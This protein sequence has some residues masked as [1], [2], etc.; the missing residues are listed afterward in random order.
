MFFYD[1]VL[2]ICNYEVYLILIDILL[3]NP[4]K[5]GDISSVCSCDNLLLSSFIGV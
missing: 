4:Q 3:I 1:F 5:I 2:L